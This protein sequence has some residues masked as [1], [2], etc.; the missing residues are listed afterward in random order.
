MFLF[1]HTYRAR[2]QTWGLLSTF[3]RSR[4]FKGSSFFQRV[5]GQP[6]LD[7][8][9]EG[10]DWQ[11]CDGLSVLLCFSVDLCRQPRLVVSFEV[12]CIQC[13]V[14]SSVQLVSDLELGVR[15]DP[16]AERRDQTWRRHTRIA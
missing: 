1:A 12:R 11:S 15:C 10:E 13:E 3:F 9:E 7:R 14:W 8:G 2:E 4:L 16:K 5:V 6:L